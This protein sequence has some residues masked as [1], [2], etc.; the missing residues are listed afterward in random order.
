[1]KI[2]ISTDLYY[3]M[4]NGIAQFSHNLAVGL[5][6][7]GHDVL[8]LA[9]SLT[10]K[11]SI[12]PQPEGFRVAYLTSRKLPIY[13]DMITPNLEGKKLWGRRIP[14]VFYKNGMHISYL[15]YPE[16]KKILGEFRPDIIHNQTPGP[17]ALAVL[18][19]S[20]RHHVPLVSTG[21]AYPGNLTAQVKLGAAK[22]P[23]DAF[24][25]WYFGIF[26]KSSDYATM[27]TRIAL[28]DLAPKS[29]RVFKAKVE[30][31]SNGID[32]SRFKPGKAPVA[33]YKKY[34]IDPKAP[35]VL[36]IG[37]IDREKSLYVLMRAFALAA[38]S[39]PEAQLVLVGDGK[40]MDS[41]RDTAAKLG[42]DPK[43]HFLGRVVGE[44]LPELY[45]MG[46]VF[47]ITSET[48]TQSIVLMEAL[49]SGLPVVAVDAGAIRELVK[50]NRNGILRKP[51]AVESL[52]R[53]IVKL[54]GDP[55]RRARYSA[56]S[57]KIVAR[58]D[59]SHTIAKVE[60]I[61]SKVL[62]NRASRAKK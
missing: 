18:T 24:L 52:A 38:E 15:P 46:T 28:R 7:R 47:A 9:P 56:E 36:Y 37:R 22:K 17:I 58:H 20:R 19:Y 6:R 5:A 2:V 40:D 27:P 13:P 39:V 32:L 60:T 29:G 14:R 45:K 8:V 11:P 53:G 44:D 35:V 49:A 57:L 31:M 54:L 59:I 55:E 62:A 33:L 12:E 23:T 1:M 21:H 3:P 48:E 51:G 41:A 43:T 50:N 61:Y 4:I 25:R 34:G 16:I 30:A 26:I 10:G 42:I